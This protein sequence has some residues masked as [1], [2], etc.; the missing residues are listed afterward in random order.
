MKTTAALTEAKLGLTVLANSQKQ[1]VQKS[2]R[3]TKTILEAGHERP[4]KQT[5]R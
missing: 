1:S 3:N 5:G 2:Q 4:I